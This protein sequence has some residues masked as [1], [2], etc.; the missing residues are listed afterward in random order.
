MCDLS[1]WMSSIRLRASGTLQSVDSTER[2]TDAF[3]VWVFSLTYWQKEMHTAEHC[4]PDPWSR[5]LQIQML[6]KNVSKQYQVTSAV[7]SVC[8]V[9]ITAMFV[10][11]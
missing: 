7:I 10:L 6:G 5:L 1:V 11:C 9:N 3:L 8:T 4:Q 2:R